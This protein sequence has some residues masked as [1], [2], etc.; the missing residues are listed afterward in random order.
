MKLPSLTFI[1][2]ILLMMRVSAK[3]PK[4]KNFQIRLTDSL[5]SSN[6]YRLGVQADV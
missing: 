3:Y 5:F 1:A 2:C 6:T 4:L